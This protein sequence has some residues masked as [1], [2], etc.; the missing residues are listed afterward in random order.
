MDDTIGIY[1]LFNEDGSVTVNIHTEENE[2][3]ANIPNIDSNYEI[4]ISPQGYVRDHR[5]TD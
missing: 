5:F 1:I 3:G 2:D 4:A